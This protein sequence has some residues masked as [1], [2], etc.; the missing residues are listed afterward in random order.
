M[1][2]IIIIIITRAGGIIVC[3]APEVFVFE[4]KQAS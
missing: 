1:H 3:E 4:Q 2:I